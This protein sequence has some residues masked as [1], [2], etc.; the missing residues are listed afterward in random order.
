MVV[1]IADPPYHAQVW[2]YPPRALI[3]M[4]CEVHAI[5]DL[6]ILNFIPKHVL[7]LGGSKTKYLTSLYSG[8]KLG[9]SGISATKH[10]IG[11]NLNI[12]YLIN[13]QDIWLEFGYPMSGWIPSWIY[14]WNLAIQYPARYVIGYS[15]GYLIGIWITNIQLDTY[16]QPSIQLDV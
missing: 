13:Q 16:I 12:Q 3:Q 14:G 8:P 4:T 6:L 11:W 2:E 15:A 7:M 5:I 1:I 10:L 9:Y